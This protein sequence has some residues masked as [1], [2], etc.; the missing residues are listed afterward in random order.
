MDYLGGHGTRGYGKV[1]FS[2]FDVKV[3][4]GSI[5]DAT[6]QKLTTILKDVEND[7]LLSFQA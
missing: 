4:D 3:I 7:E 1:K 5:N 2:G 6:K